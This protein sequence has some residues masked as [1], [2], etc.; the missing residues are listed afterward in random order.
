MSTSRTDMGTRVSRRS[1]MKSSMASGL[2]ASSNQATS[3]SV[4]MSAVRI[5]HSRPFGQYASLA[6]AS[7]ISWSPGRWRPG[8]SHDGFV[9][10]VAVAAAERAPADLERPEPCSRSR[11]IS[12]PGLAGSSISSEQ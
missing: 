7:T 1:V 6:P 2:T 8:R 12:S 5:A 4:S 3:W 9:Q 10:A 11:T